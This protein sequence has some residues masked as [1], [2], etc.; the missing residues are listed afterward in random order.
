MRMYLQGKWRNNRKAGYSSN[1][2]AT[3]PPLL[4]LRGR[5]QEW[6][7]LVIFKGKTPPI[8][9]AEAALW[10]RRRTLRATSPCAHRKERIF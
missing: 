5:A 1:A 7:P 3:H 6:C 8:R 10:L 9:R 2:C 4:G